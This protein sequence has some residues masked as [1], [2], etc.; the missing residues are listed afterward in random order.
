M[1]AAVLIS[2]FWF[3]Y[4]AGVGIYFP[5]WSLYLRENAGLTATEVGIVLA[6][7]PLVGLITQPWWGYVADRTGHRS[8]VL[9]VL[10]LGAA[11]GFYTMSTVSGF[12]PW[13]VVSSLTAAFATAVVPVLFSI[14][15]G[16]LRDSG[17]HAFGYTR[18]WGTIGFLILVITFPWWLHRHQRALRLIALPG[19]P[20]EPGLEVMF[21][22]IAMFAAIAA[23]V[24]LFLPRHGVVAAR[25]GGGEWR[26]LLRHPPLLRLTLFTLLG[27]LCTQGPMVLF[28]MYIRALGGSIDTVGTMWVFMVMLEIP[29]VLASGGALVRFGVRALI[30]I[31]ALAA[32]VRWLICAVS[33]D[34]TTIYAAQ[35]L[36]GVV[37]AGLMLGPPLYLDAIVPAELRSSG[38]TIVSMISIGIGAML[39]T[40][41]S[42]WLMDHYGIHAPYLIGGTGAVLLALAARWLIPPPRRLALPAQIKPS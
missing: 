17:P 36:H 32:G 4:F 6:A 1:S 3:F 29:L 23:A 11:A 28:P 25:A 37:V 18:V 31:G 14:S 30:G 8:S 34:M 33:G 9:V 24:A 42:G 13:M 21:P 20:S 35:L 27:Y 10:S 39:S 2:L 7:W 41:L 26:H 5:Y 16:A 38:Q 15:F 12:I 22:L 40:V 19:G